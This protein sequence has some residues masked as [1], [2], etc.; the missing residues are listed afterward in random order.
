MPKTRLSLYYLATYTTLTGIAFLIAPQT[1][2]AMLFSNDPAR[3]G[4]L[5]PRLAGLMLLTI[6]I[7]VIQVI[8]HR[9]ESLYPTTLFV[10]GVIVSVLIAL[11][12]YSSDPA[13][14]AIIGV[15][16][17]GLILTGVSYLRDKG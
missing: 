7:I 9:V 11:Y 5:G 16:A 6:G 2:L 1:V 14:L 4:D 15:V 3:W 12:S 13:F 8:R 17:V 10:R